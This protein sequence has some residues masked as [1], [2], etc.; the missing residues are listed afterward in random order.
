MGGDIEKFCYA[1]TVRS[2]PFPQSF[3]NKFRK[4]D[5]IISPIP[6]LIG[7]KRVCLKKVYSFF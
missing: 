3:V 6:R 2:P 1:A 5:G 4:T 7:N